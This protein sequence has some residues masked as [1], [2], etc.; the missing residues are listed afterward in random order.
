ML[1]YIRIY[2]YIYIY[3]YFNTLQNTSTRFTRMTCTD[4]GFS[5]YSGTTVPKDCLM[6]II[7]N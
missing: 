7:S 6:T 5:G 2:I 4:L 1:T 3:I